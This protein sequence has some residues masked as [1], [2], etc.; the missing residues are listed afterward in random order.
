VKTKELIKTLT[1][2]SDIV[3]SVLFTPDGKHIVSGSSDKTVR[4]W[5]AVTGYLIKILLTDNDPPVRSVSVS[6]PI[7]S[8]N[9]ISKNDSDI[10]V[11]DPGLD[12]GITINNN[13]I[14]GNVD[15]NASADITESD[16]AAADIGIV[17]NTG[18]GIVDK[19]VEDNDVTNKSESVLPEIETE[20]NTVTPKKQQQSSLKNMNYWA[21]VND[22]AKKVKSD[23]KITNFGNILNKAPP[24]PP[25]RQMTSNTSNNVFPPKIKDEN[26]EKNKVKPI[27]D[28]YV[29]E[30]QQNI[31]QTDNN[32]NKQEEK[33]DDTVV[34]I[35]E[36][37]SD[38]TLDPATESEDVNENDNN[39]IETG[40]DFSEDSDQFNFLRGQQHGGKTRRRRSRK[41]KTKKG[42]KS[43]RK[44]KKNKKT[45]KTRK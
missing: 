4:V 7:V 5:D 19:N 10:T 1:G 11:S 44:M 39:R 33:N 42:K 25:A 13:V 15:E 27:V 9:V 16:A 40:K 43:T 17:N 23:T 31:N 21:R 14:S 34:E 41:M 18:K 24:P 35:N 32:V 45:K 37:Q 28:N 8:S 36:N 38:F 29:T 6:G 26:V 12:S 30:Q 3:T 2:H 20:Q 22:A